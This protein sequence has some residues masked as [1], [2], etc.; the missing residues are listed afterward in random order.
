MEIGSKYISNDGKVFIV[1][2]LRSIDS[3]R[4]VFYTN[5]DNNKNYS[6]TKESFESRFRILQN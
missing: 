1:I 3:T 2:E 5:I 4:W 6:C